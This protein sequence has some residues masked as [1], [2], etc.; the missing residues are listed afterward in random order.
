[1]QH[2][3]KEVGRVAQSN[4]IVLII[5]ETGTGKELIGETSTTSRTIATARSVKVNL[6]ALPETFV[7]SE[8]FG[9]EKGSFTGA[10]AQHKG[11]FEW[12]TRARSSW[13]RLAICRF[14]RAAQTLAGPP[15]K[16]VRAGWWHQLVTT[17]LPR[18]GGHQP[19]L[20]KED[21]AAGAVP[22]GP[23]LSPG[24]GGRSTMPPLRERKVD[25]PRWWS[26]SC[27][28][29]LSGD[30]PPARIAEEAMSGAH[31]LRLAG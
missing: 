2:I 8:L 20:S 27:K 18:G 29:P 9:H 6:T 19:V 17:R 23:V 30:A 15:G 16:A 24:G 5:G 3:Y 22:G 7:E 28:V 4:A 10:V 21:V 26:I 25:I 1:M 12:R 11:K 13:T 14:Q 31:G